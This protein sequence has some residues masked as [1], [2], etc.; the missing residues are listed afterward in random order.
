MAVVSKHLGFTDPVGFHDLR[1]TAI[2]LMRSERVALDVVQTLAGH[3][4]G[5][6]SVTETVYDQSITPMDDLKQAVERLAHAVAASGNGD[7]TSNVVE[8]QTK[9]AS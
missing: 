3:R 2:T 7:A 1:R 8:L 4:R 5:G 6:G 9:I